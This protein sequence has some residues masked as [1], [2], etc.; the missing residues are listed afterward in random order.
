M[1]FKYRLLLIAVL[2]LAGTAM[3]QGVRPITAEE[4][5]RIGLE[6][7]DQLRAAVAEAEQAE[8]VYRQVRTSRLPAFNTLA[9]YT[10]LSSNIPEIE[11]EVPDLPGLEPGT[12]TLAPVELNRYY[13]EIS[14]EQPIFT[15]F[16]LRNTI[17]AAAHQAEAAVQAAEQER[18]DLAFAIRQAYWTLYQARAL[19]DVADLAVRQVEAHLRDVQTRV[20]AGAALR[21]DLLAAQ[22]RRSEVLLERI[23]AAN[24]VELARLELNRLAGLPLDTPL[25]P[26]D[27]V[28]I[29]ALPGETE[30]L[31]RTA[32][33][34]RPGL[35]ALD[36]QVQ[37]LRATVQATRSSL[38]PDLALTGR[39]VYARPNQYFFVEQ[40][41]FRGTWEAGVAMTWRL[42]YWGRRSQETN[43]A[44]A[45]LEAA[46]ARLESARESVIVDVRRRRLEV[47]RAVERLAVTEESVE[48]AEEVFRMLTFRYREGAALSSEVLDAEVALHQARAAHARAVAEYAVARA[49]LTHALGQIW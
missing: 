39:Y 38:L 26:A 6:Q 49:G 2:C 24:A 29:D 23:D 5:V 31:A 15:G 18:V 46:E 10:R 37:S 4:A 45:R 8:A 25:L 3:A 7:N 43:E 13:A 48:T 44:R 27:T 41:V 42:W 16:R 21:S 47:L 22:T 36:A 30:A 12:F 32:L 19:Y 34:A 28:E 35:G 17:R 40:D 33:E 1:V 9:S 20:D 11:F 14:V